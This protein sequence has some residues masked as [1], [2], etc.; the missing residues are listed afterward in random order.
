MSDFYWPKQIKPLINKNYSTSRGANVLAT[1][2]TGGLPMVALDT[3][4]ESPPFNLN[5]VLSNLRMQVLLNFYDVALN[6]G[7]NSFLMDLD[8]GNGVEEHRCFIAPG[9]WKPSKPNNG[10]WYLSLTVIAKVTSSQLSDCDS[11]YQL[12]N[13]YGD[14][15]RKVLDGLSAWV[16]AMPK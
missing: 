15:T 7:A 1:P 3:T 2:L 14:G 5:F 12:F 13:C 11:L 9:T 8:S 6:H 4:L 10:N 16:E